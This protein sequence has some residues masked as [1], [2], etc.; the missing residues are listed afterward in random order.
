MV[1]GFDDT[2][3]C[4]ALA[5]DVAVHSISFIVGGRRRDIRVELQIYEFAAFVLHGFVVVGGEVRGLESVEMLI[6]LSSSSSSGSKLS[7]GFLQPLSMPRVWHSAINHVTVFGNILNSKCYDI[8]T[9]KRN[10]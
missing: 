7:V 6:S 2:V 9:R 1:L 4:A 8:C 10:I 5:G 3:G